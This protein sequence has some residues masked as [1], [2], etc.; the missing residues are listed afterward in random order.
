MKTSAMYI[1]FDEK[2]GP[3]AQNWLPADLPLE[4]RDKIPMMVMN[5]ASNMEELP[6]GVAMIPVTAY[7]MK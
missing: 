3:V 1:V 6:K 7:S 4:M 5:I 2:L